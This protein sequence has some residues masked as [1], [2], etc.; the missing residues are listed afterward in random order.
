MIDDDF[1]HAEELAGSFFG[2]LASA[3]RIMDLRHQR[4][5]SGSDEAVLKKVVVS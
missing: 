3:N 5:A 4:S 1:R 2:L